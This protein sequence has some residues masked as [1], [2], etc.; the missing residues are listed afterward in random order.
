M[1]GILNAGTYSKSSTSPTHLN[2]SSTR[3]KN[4]VSDIINPMKD[5]V[6]FDTEFTS[7][8]GCNEK[9]WDKNKNQFRELVQLSAIKVNGD[10][11]HTV[12]TFDAYSKP[13]KNPVLSEYLKNLTGIKQE[14][15]D[16]A[17]PAKQVIEEFL[18]WS[19]G[20][21]CYSYGEDIDI[22]NE[23]IGDTKNQIREERFINIKPFFKN[24]GVPVEKYNS[25]KLH[26]FF[27]IDM[28]GHEHNALFDTKSIL[29][30]IRAVLK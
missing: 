23:N 5:F 30:S 19:D 21:Y 12:D 20:L 26:K 14:D 29:E 9:G 6:I 25:G 24:R 3:N 17:R 13:I 18:D 2:P 28:D 1:Q 15:I 16:K 27:N 10:N 11:L 8:K 4:C 7:W 22:L